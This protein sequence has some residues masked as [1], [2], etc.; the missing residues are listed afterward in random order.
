MTKSMHYAIAAI[1]AVSG[2]AIASIGVKPIFADL[3]ILSAYYLLLAGSWNLLA[4][5]AGQYSFAHVG[6]AAAGAYGTA[7]IVNAFG[8]SGWL[9]F[10]II[11]VFTAAIGGLLGLV[12]LRVRGVQLPLITF[13]FAGAFAVFLAAASDITGGSM[14]MQLPKLVAG[15]DRS[16]YLILSG[17]LVAAFFVIQNLVLDGRIGLLMQSVRDEEEVAR[18]IG[19]DI[20]RIKV[21]AFMITAGLAGLAGAFYA[22]YVGVLAPSMLSMSEMGMV[23]AMAVIGGLGHRYGALVGVIVIRSLEHF[24]RGF[25]AEY[26]L[27]IITAVALLVVLFFRE[28]IIAAVGKRLDRSV[29]QRRWASA[30]AS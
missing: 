20:F 29:Q 18:G 28:G 19:V 8:V 11:P 21:Y 9:A 24:V 17:L 7:A 26:T 25:G 22:N 1:F 16:P 6:L 13:A 12:A 3:L 27:V 23:V 15:F 2:V 30:K 5:F 10:L 14:G 4:G